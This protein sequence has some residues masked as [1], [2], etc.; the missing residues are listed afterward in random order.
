MR[1]GDEDAAA[2]FAAVG[3][4]ANAETIRLAANDVADR[5]TETTA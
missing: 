4:M 1:I 3:A 2:L 5:S